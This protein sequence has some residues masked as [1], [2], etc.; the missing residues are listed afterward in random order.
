MAKDIGAALGPALRSDPVPSSGAD[1]VRYAGGR[2][3]L[4][5]QLSGM[6]GPPAK[7]DYR[8]PDEWKSASTRWRT[9]SRRAQRLDE[10]G[11][12]GKQRRGTS[13]GADLTPAQKRRLRRE[14]TRRKREQMIERGMRARLYALVRTDTPKAGGSSNTRER[15][16]PAY[17][18][19]GVLLD[20]AMVRDVLESLEEGETD[21]A[22]DEFIPAFF[23]SYGVD[24]ETLE[25]EE[26]HWLKVWPEGEREPD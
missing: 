2:R 1:L 10:E 16:M 8:T 9:A 26:V 25:I 13:K 4:A 22:A 15:T 20:K 5:E 7:G 17:P 12:A 6:S 11:R 18:S 23:E 3:A 24:P 14:A 21:A 19:P